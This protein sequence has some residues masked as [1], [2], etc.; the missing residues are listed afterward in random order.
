MIT[1]AAVIALGATVSLVANGTLTDD[2]PQAGDLVVAAAGLE[3]L[4]PDLSGPGEVGVFITNHGP[5]RH[6]FTIDALDLDV[7]LP[8][9]TSRCFEFEAPAGTYAVY[10]AVPGHR[11]GGMVATLT[12]ADA[13]F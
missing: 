3:F 12:V 5:T 11:E 10:C 1:G 4:P 2:V 9:S 8:A 13:G 6:T 7:E